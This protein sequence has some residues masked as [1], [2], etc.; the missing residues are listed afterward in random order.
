MLADVRSAFGGD[1]QLESVLLL[2]RLNAMAEAPWAT[3]HRYD[4][5]MT[6]RDLSD[7]LRD[8]SMAPT[9][10]WIDGKNHRGYRKADFVDV[11]ERF[12]PL[13]D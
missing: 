1:E 2:A 6:A 7:I 5:P 13:P 3:Y 8:V 11:W 10:L 9:Q 4:K 12:C